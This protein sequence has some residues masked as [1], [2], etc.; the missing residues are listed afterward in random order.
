MFCRFREFGTHATKW[1][2]VVQRLSCTREC[3]R[4][5]REAFSV[6]SAWRCSER[7]RVREELLLGKSSL[8]P[9]WL[10]EEVLFCVFFS[11]AFSLTWEDSFPFFPADAIMFVHEARTGGKETNIGK[12][13]GAL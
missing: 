3:Y 7:D 12:H 13:S 1:R 10:V 2:E 5:L 4:R 9:P 6:V 11:V 8:I